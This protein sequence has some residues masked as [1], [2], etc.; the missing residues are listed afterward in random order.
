MANIAGYRA[1][2]EAAVGDHLRFERAI[3][4]QSPPVR[5]VGAAR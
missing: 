2:V 3:A 1:V 5:P 4:R